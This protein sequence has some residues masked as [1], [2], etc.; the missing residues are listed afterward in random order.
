V[1]LGLVGGTVF[2]LVDGVFGSLGEVGAMGPAL[3]AF[4]APVLFLLIGL[5]SVVV[6]EE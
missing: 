5:W 4:V 6:V 1:A 3:A 2:I